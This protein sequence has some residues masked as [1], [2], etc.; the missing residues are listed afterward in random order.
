MLAFVIILRNAGQVTLELARLDLFADAHVILV[1]RQTGEP[2]GEVMFVKRLFA[3]KLGSSGPSLLRHWFPP[4]L[5]LIDGLVVHVGAEEGVFLIVV[6]RF[7]GE[8]V[9][10]EW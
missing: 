3:T 6:D 7:L 2:L 9:Y 4:V 10:T 5:G 1:Y 8:A